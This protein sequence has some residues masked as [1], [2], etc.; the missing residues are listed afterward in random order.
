MF[1]AVSL[2]LKSVSEPAKVNFEYY[3]IM[4]KKN[5]TSSLSS[6]MPTISKQ[7][8]EN[9]YTVT[10]VYSSLKRVNLVLIRGI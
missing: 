5:Y 8:Q 1:N 7:M 3:L 6:S 10:K 2:T 9:R 4:S